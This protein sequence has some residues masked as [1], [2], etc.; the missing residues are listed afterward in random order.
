MRLVNAQY[1]Q[2]YLAGELGKKFGR[3]RRL[4]CQT[5]AQALRLISL[6]RPDF[7][8]HMKK[9]AADGVRFHVIADR[10]SRTEDELPLPAGK[11]LI[12]SMEVAGA[13]GALGGILETVAGIAL[14]AISIIYPPTGPYAA[15]LAAAEFSVGANLALG[16]I[17]SLLTR[18]Q[19]GNGSSS[20]LQS[21]AFNG[22]VSTQQ[23][24]APVPV[25]Y[26]RMLIGGQAISASLNAVDSSAAPAETGAI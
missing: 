22:P 14:I 23:Q 18:L 20:S 8:A 2:V 5:P 26:G 24:G 3:V 15:S 16:G 12:I 9:L 7:K 17:T 25:V 11:R 21:Y 10:R 1:T 6:E 13:K 19:K 4:V